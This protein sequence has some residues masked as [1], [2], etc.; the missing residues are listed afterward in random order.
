MDLQFS[1][2]YSIDSNTDR[3]CKSET[4]GFLFYSWYLEP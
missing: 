2:Y 1:D 4:E 3:T